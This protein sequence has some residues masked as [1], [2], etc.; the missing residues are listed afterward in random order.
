MLMLEMLV[1]Y[2]FFIRHSDTFTVKTK[3]VA[4]SYSITKGKVAN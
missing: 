3:S 1:S 2:A 4:I